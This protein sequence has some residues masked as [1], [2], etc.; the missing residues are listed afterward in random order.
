ML[1]IVRRGVKSLRV[2]ALRRSTPR[3]L[4]G[5]AH[6]FLARTLVAAC[7]VPA[8]PSSLT[9]HEAR[10]EDVQPLVELVN[11]AYGRSTTTEANDPDGWTSEDGI[12]AGPR[13]Q[14]RDVRSILEHPASAMLVAEPKQPQDGDGGIV[15]CVHVQRREDRPGRAPASEIGMLSVRPDRQAEGLGSRILAAAEDHARTQQGAERAILHVLTIREELL[16]WYAERGYEATGERVPFEPEEPQ[17]SLVGD[18]V[19]AVLAKRL[20]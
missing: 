11:D 12:L 16:D 9:I 5:S 3:A 1:G 18:L 6:R 19:F 7:S 13:V 14:S 8:A 20:G 2:Q 4:D 17:R 15:G 10:L